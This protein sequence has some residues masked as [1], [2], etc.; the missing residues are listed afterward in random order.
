MPRPYRVSGPRPVHDTAPGE[1]FDADLSAE[2]EDALL[3]AGRV[4]LVPR[5][6]LVTG[7]RE[8]LGTKPDHTFTHAFP[9]A[10]ER[11]LIEGGHIRPVADDGEDLAALNKTEL[12]TRADEL[13]L[14]VPARATRDELLAAIE[15]HEPGEQPEEEE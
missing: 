12:R 7:N 3:Q 8:V 11:V 1:E 15:E 9:L 13:G 10:Q 14:D 4:E 5:T 2:E 6:Y